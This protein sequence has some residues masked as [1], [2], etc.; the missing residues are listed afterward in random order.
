V[1]DQTELL[2][3]ALVDDGPATLRICRSLL[4]AAT[5]GLLP[6]SR[7]AQSSDDETTPSAPNGCWGRSAGDAYFTT[8]AGD[9]PTRRARDGTPEAHRVR[10]RV[11][12]LRAERPQIHR[13]VERLFWSRHD[14][15]LTSRRF[16]S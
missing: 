14:L 11:Q 3:L 13:C 7:A 16:W 4:R 6:P 2:T 9:D 5:A 8:A 15:S 1:L 12:L 10:G